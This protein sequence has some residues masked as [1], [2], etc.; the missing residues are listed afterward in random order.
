MKYTFAKSTFFI[1]DWTREWN[2]IPAIWL[3][4]RLFITYWPMTQAKLCYATVNDVLMKRFD[5]VSMAHD[6]HLTRKFDKYSPNVWTFLLWWLRRMSSKIF[7]LSGK[8]MRA[9]SSTSLDLI[10]IVHSSHA[11]KSKQIICTFNERVNFTF[12]STLDEDRAT[13]FVEDN[14]SFFTVIY[15][16]QLYIFRVFQLLCK[17]EAMHFSTPTDNFHVQHCRFWPFF[18]HSF[19]CFMCSSRVALCS[20]LLWVASC[21]FFRVCFDDW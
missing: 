6:S 16:R 2:A 15:N 5:G 20:S 11:Q 8:C 13:F 14:F 1:Q 18:Y 21:G 9:Q 7:V 19:V 17:Y 12:G 4:F 3:M 10:H